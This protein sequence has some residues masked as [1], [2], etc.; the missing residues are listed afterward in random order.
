MNSNIFVRLTSFMLCLIMILSLAA[1]NTPA[2][3]EGSTTGGIPE[4]EETESKEMHEETTDEEDSDTIEEASENGSESTSEDDTEEE[5][6]TLCYHDYVASEEGHWKEAC[7]VCGKA[8]GRV[9]AHEI[10][11]KIKDQGDRLLYMYYCNIC[12]YVVYKQELSYDINV[13]IPPTDLAATRCYNYSPKYIFEDNIGFTRFT[14]SGASNGGIIYA[15]EDTACEDVSGRYLIM[16]VRLSTSGSI[17]LE[18][19]SSNGKNSK[20]ATPCEISDQWCTLIIDMAKVTDKSGNGYVADGGGD[21]YLELLNIHMTSGSIL[22]KDE[23]LDI[24][25]MTVV[26]TLEDAREFA[27]NDLIYLYSNILTNPFPSIEGNACHH[28]YNYDENGHTMKSC[29]KCGMVGTA[30]LAPHK[31]V[32]RVNGSEY[33]YNCECGYVFDAKKTVSEDVELFLSP[34]YIAKHANSQNFFTSGIL[35]A[36]GDGEAYA[37]IYGREKNS[38]G[39]NITDSLKWWNIYSNGAAVTGQY[40][41]IKYRVG[42]NGLGQTQL[43]MYLST[44]RS[45]AVDETDGFGLTVTEDNEWHV[46]VI[47]MSMAHGNSS[48]STFK[49]AEDGTYTL[50]FLQVR[51]FTGAVAKADDYTDIAYI[52]FCD[53]LDDVKV[54]VVEDSYYWQDTKGIKTGSVVNK[55]EG[56]SFTEEETTEEETTASTEVIDGHVIEEKHEGNTYSFSCSHC[57]EE[58]KTLTTSNGVNKFYSPST[59]FSNSGY[60]A[61]KELLA[62]SDGQVFTRITSN[63]K[64]AFEYYFVNRQ[65]APATDAGACRYI[66][67]RVR[68]SDKTKHINVVF[69]TEK[70]FTSV[71]INNSLNSNE[72]TTLVLDMDQLAKMSS[73]STN[74]IKHFYIYPGALGENYID[75]AYVALCDNWNE[76]ASL[77]AG[78]EQVTLITSTSVAGG[79]VSASDGSC[80]KHIPMETANGNTYTYRCA[81][82]GKLMAEKTISE[83]IDLFISP[84]KLGKAFQ[85]SSEI[86][87]ENGIIYK[88]F[89]CSGTAG[90]IYSHDFASVPDSGRFLIIKMRLNNVNAFCVEASSTSKLHSISQEPVKKKGIWQTVA[91]DLSSYTDYVI[92]KA[93][94]DLN[95]RFT[96]YGPVGF[97]VDI[98]YIAIVNDLSQA[99]TLI[100]EAEYDLYKSWKNTGTVVDTASAGCKA[101]VTT[102]VLANGVYTYA[103][104]AICGKS[105]DGAKKEIPESVSKF[106]TAGMLASKAKYNANVALCADDSGEAFARLTSGNGGAFEYYIVKKDGTP[107]TDLGKDFRY[108]VF[109]VRVS[110]VKCEYNFS[111]ATKDGKGGGISLHT[112]TSTANEWVTIVADMDSIGKLEANSGGD[113]TLKQFF[114]YTSA[115]GTNTLDIA[116]VAFCNTWEEIGGISG[117]DTAMLMTAGNSKGVLVSTADGSTIAE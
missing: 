69:A 43:R 81:S 58:F 53:S 74:P 109:K 59:L 110:D 99:A 80:L 87:E 52:A 33:I 16:K 45:G 47:D 72:W 9:Q 76:L 50:K 31:A 35:M 89:T 8:A 79:K 62:D 55:A 27:K 25:Y 84:D 67:M 61:V 39:N 60:K 40:L 113:Y 18:I 5:S 36:D 23:Y 88:R 78:D 49:R 111:I 102:E 77:C 97:T 108:V 75:I 104:C 63:D 64:T 73:S 101:C 66:I 107:V 94:G 34:S 26:E 19:R 21:F 28:E 83:S 98:A 65:G 37:R 11:E 13:Y 7:D 15:Y 85:F 91:I 44:T 103:S 46:A 112:S 4:I 14:S 29:D 20:T 106:Y 42:N 86:A 6:E 71:R 92:N 48:G 105:F 68:V 96:G 54:L 70:T 41:V 116:C 93:N 57:D 24:S 32:E 95:L 115:T 2:Q 38:V 117:D 51:P 100:D 22:A 12:E 30:E 56:P 17:N 10:S 82:C 114:M 90:H 1:C 3:E